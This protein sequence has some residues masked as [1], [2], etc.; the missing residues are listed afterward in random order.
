MDR[1]AYRDS[2]VL[3]SF[4]LACG[5]AAT[6]AAVPLVLAAGDDSISGVAIPYGVAAIAMAANALT[7][8]R[9]KSMAT[10]LYVV[11]WIAVVYGIL[12]MI[13]VPL[14]M[15]VIGTCP[16]SGIVCGPGFSHPF[17]GG[18]SAGIVV[19]ILAGALALQVGF[20]GLRALYRRPRNQPAAAS[21]IATAPPT[22]VVPPHK[23]A[24]SPPLPIGPAPD[25]AAGSSAAQL[26]IA[27]QPEAAGPA[28][29]PV[30]VKKPRTKRPPK[31]VAELAP[32]PEPPELP[33]HPEPAE[34]PPH[35]SGS[36]LDP[37]T[38][39]SS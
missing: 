11:A 20:F 3:W 1:T 13:A 29:A 23:T 4:W 21:A 2:R 18:E 24:P 33:P 10:A 26:P 16:A 39:T 14:Q 9:G 36:D 25:A 35:P 15:A 34:L 7:Y 19:G 38:T 12:R 8:P 22:R 17:T 6:G 32:P 28:T 30:A 5:L 27:D 37:S 31:P